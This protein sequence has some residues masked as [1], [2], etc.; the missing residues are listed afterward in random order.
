MNGCSQW[1][2]DR[3]AT[4]KRGSGSGSKAL[5][6][7]SDLSTSQR[8]NLDDR[9]ASSWRSWPSEIS[10]RGPTLSQHSIL[11]R[12]NQYPQSQPLSQT[13]KK[14]AAMGPGG[15]GCQPNRSSGG[16]LRWV[17]MSP[18]SAS[19]AR[20]HSRHIATRPIESRSPGCRDESLIPGTFQNVKRW[21]MEILSIC[22]LRLPANRRYK[23][24]LHR[25]NRE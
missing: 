12:S 19:G 23:P 6:M 11:P 25:I 4:A 17:R 22:Q 13:A 2:T 9:G 21:L 14:Y 24:L 5:P 1:T 8:R 7:A 10:N 15:L 16:W 20:G 3:V 18:L